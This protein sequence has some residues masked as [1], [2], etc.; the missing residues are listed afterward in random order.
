LRIKFPAEITSRISPFCFQ[1]C[2]PIY[3]ARPEDNLGNTFSDTLKNCSSLYLDKKSLLNLD[4]KGFDIRLISLAE[5]NILAPLI[6]KSYDLRCW[7]TLTWPDSMKL[8]NWP[9][10]IHLYLTR[11]LY[12]RKWTKSQQRISWRV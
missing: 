11:I 5:A 1:I 9:Y 12:V 4:C 10:G 8:S 7:S 6:S 3:L 2:T